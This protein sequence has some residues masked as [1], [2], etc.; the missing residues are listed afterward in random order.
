MGG[1]KAKRQTF[2]LPFCLFALPLPF[3]LLIKL[4]FYHKSDNQF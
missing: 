1:K 4:D 2:Y 3:C